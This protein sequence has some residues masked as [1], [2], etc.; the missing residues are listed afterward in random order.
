MLTDITPLS[1]EE[2]AVQFR[3]EMI[4]AGGLQ[5]RATTSV[6]WLCPV[7]GIIAADAPV[8]ATITRAERS[9]IV[10][11]FGTLRHRDVQVAIMRW[12]VGA[13][14]ADRR[15]RIL[16]NLIRPDGVAWTREKTVDAVWPDAPEFWELDSVVALRELVRCLATHRAFPLRGYDLARHGFPPE[17]APPPPATVR[18]G[19]R[20]ALDDL[21][22]IALWREG[23]LDG[24]GAA[25]DAASLDAMTRVVCALAAAGIRAPRVFL[26]PEGSALAQW[27]PSGAS[28]EVVPGGEEFRA[29]AMPGDATL[30]GRV[31][32]DIVALRVYLGPRGGWS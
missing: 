20:Q 21:D 22:E 1:R 24:E 3:R 13:D 17:D 23:W 19:V 26:A 27:G 30:T 25:P 8:S 16:A 29:Y 15:P 2:R 5:W 32:G 12:P 9:F 7:E 28:L 6:E 18:D 11:G 4:A 10:R 31:D 14:R